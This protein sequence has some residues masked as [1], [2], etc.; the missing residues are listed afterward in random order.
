MPSSLTF[1]SRSGFS[2]LSSGGHSAAHVLSVGHSLLLYADDVGPGQSGIHSTSLR[3]SILSFVTLQSVFQR[4]YRKSVLHSGRLHHGSDGRVSPC[5]EEEE[6]GLHPHRLLHLLHHRLL[7]RHSGFYTNVKR[8]VV[9]SSSVSA[10]LTECG[11][12]A[13]GLRWFQQQQQQ[14]L[15]VVN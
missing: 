9:C 10:A 13:K 3:F 2:G 1:R 12:G 8:D 5:A 6:E 14:Q 15:R 11:D 4:L 7:Q